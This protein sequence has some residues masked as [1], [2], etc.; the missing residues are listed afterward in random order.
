MVLCAIAS[1]NVLA[2]D[3]IEVTL[4]GDTGQKRTFRCTTAIW[5]GLEYGLQ[6]WI[7]EV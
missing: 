1:S 6:V 7:P 3:L 5:L 4:Y 2:F